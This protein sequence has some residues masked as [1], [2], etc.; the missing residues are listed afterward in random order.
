MCVQAWKSW[1]GPWRPD[2]AAAR[3]HKFDQQWS[4][5]QFCGLK[6]CACRHASPGAV[7]GGLIRLLPVSYAA[8]SGAIG[9]QA[10]LF[11]KMLSGLLRTSVRGEPQ[12]GHPFA[13]ATVVLLVV[14]ATFWVTRLNRVGFPGLLTPPLCNDSDSDA[15]P[16]V[17]T[18][19]RSCCIPAVTLLQ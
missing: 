13:W 9:T 1:C 8:F 12:M 14:S 3:T 5:Y 2:Q 7:P 10:V 15:C 11:A 6:R 18:E 17:Q 16:P 19:Q 4:K